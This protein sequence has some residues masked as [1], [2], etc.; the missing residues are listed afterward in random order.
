MPV[1]DIVKEPEDLEP[2]STQHLRAVLTFERG[3]Q[4]TGINSEICSCTH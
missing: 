2:S 3:I 4:L 1:D